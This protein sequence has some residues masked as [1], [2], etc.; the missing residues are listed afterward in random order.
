[1]GATGKKVGKKERTERR[2]P[3]PVTEYHKIGAS[4]LI[5]RLH[6]HTFFFFFFVLNKQSSAVVVVTVGWLG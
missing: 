1:M 4:A 5:C 3:G 6:T 2:E